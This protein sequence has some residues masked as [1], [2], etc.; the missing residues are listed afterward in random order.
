MISLII[1]CYNEEKRLEHSVEKMIPLLLSFTKFEI[2]II[3][4][5][6]LDKT[7]DVIESLEKKYPFV[8]HYSH[9]KNLGKGKA[10]QSGIKKSLGTYIFFIDA[11]YT[12]PLP[13]TK[14]LL[15]QMKKND[16]VVGVRNIRVDQYGR[17]IPFLRRIISAVGKSMIKIVLP[18]MQDTQCG[19]K[20]FSREKALLLAQHQKTNRWLFDLEYLIIAHENNWQ[21]LEVPITWTH[22]EDSKFRPFRDSIQSFFVFF[23]IILRQKLKLYKIAQQ[24]NQ[25]S[26]SKTPLGVTN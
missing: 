11:D 4:D 10:I 18:S 21:V 12:S 24:K 9:E 22:T 7:I 25:Q 26:T 13:E 15:L 20:C 16:F 19:I 1:P 17:K 2:I 5:G 8:R 3:D 23:I 14:N 6:S